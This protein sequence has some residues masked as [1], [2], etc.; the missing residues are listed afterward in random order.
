MQSRKHLHPLA[1][2]GVLAVSALSGVIY[3]GC[4]PGTTG[5]AR[6]LAP[7]SEH[8]ITNIV[9]ALKVDV[10]PALPQPISSATELGAGLILAALAAWQTW[11]HAHVAKLRKS[12]QA[13]QQAKAP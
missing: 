13:Q 2:A 4:V 8:T 12:A 9:T 7:E 11:T 5:L 1:L 3:S 10:A 6:P